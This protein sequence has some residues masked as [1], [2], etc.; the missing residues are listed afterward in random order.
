MFHHLSA[1]TRWI[2][3]LALKIDLDSSRVLCL[4]QLSLA[5]PHTRSLSQNTELTG[6]K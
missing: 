6:R 3:F 5:G 1:R 2:R 4:F